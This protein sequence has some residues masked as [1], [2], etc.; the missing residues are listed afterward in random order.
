MQFPMYTPSAASD[1]LT[2]PRDRLVAHNAWG[3]GQTEQ[4]LSDRNLSASKKLPT[5]LDNL[6]L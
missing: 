5:S 3:Q 2:D 6:L 1:L 4:D